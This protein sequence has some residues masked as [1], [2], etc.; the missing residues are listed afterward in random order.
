VGAIHPARPGAIPSARD[1]TAF[2]AISPAARRVRSLALCDD[3]GMRYASALIAGALVLAAACGEDQPSRDGSP[4]VLADPSRFPVVLEHDMRV[5]AR[6]DGS[7]YAEEPLDPW[8]VFPEAGA[9]PDG[10][11]RVLVRGGKV[12]IE[13]A[14]GG[15]AIAI[16]GIE[17]E[18]EFVNAAWSPDG[19]TLVFDASFTGASPAL[20]VVRADGSGLRDV[21]MGLDGDT[22]PLAWSPDA[23][24]FAFGVFG[25]AP[26][27]VSEL[28]TISADG[29]A[30]AA[31]GQFTI[32]Q[33][34]GGW[35]TAT[36][37]PDGSKIAAFGPPPKPGLRVF[38]IGGAPPLD[39]AGNVTRFSWSPDSRTI[40]YDQ[41]DAETQHIS[42]VI[43]DAST[44][45]VRELTEGFE[46]RWSPD[47]SRIAF[48][49]GAAS[50]GVSIEQAYTIR[51]DASGEAPVGPPGYYRFRDLV[52][53]ADSSELTFI[54]PAFG[55]A[56]LYRVDLSTA[57]AEP[58]GL[59]VGAVGDPPRVVEVSS[60][61]KH[62][63]LENYAS[64]A[65]AG[66]QVMDLATGETRPF[67]RGGA[68]VLDVYWG[69]EGPVIATGGSSLHVTDPVGSSARS[70]GIEGVYAGEFS[71]DG[72]RI[73]AITADGVWIVGSDGSDP[74]HIATTDAATEIAQQVDWSPDS[75]RL[76]YTISTFDQ[77]S[78]L[79]TTE[80]FVSDLGGTVT[81]VA[82][83]PRGVLLPYWSPDGA[84]LAQLRPGDNASAEIWLMDPEGGAVRLVASFE[85][86]CCG[87]LYWSP[88]STRIAVAAGFSSVSI[89]DVSSGDVLRAVTT[90][91][92]CNVNIAGW[93]ADSMTLYVY[94]AC[95]FGV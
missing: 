71:A 64:V 45:E 6:A 44:G 48:K 62:V 9:S 92:G 61:G 17:P 84:I 21:G 36:F 8:K 47:E 31:L 89:V 25:Q 88:D 94:P 24:I 59:P 79:S 7:G 20:Y 68:Q 2:V 75:T 12:V 85:G 63:L 10:A 60:D 38:D 81:E 22:T 93:S 23:R 16:A 82:S 72:S 83:D 50:L 43:G 91:G 39:F 29:A 27:Y 13:P 19:S 30:R 86:G 58:I 78:G 14:D 15:E 1:V 70:L 90:G 49:R 77:E 35:D 52:W 28:Y 76:S 87:D 67:E 18:E 5:T 95:Y 11:R 46:P 73:A 56:Q 80:A 74:R 65:D 51:P 42:V 53:S 69:P 57:A 3:A 33:G 4:S 55:Q 34:D 32:P 41:F 66:L 54:R 40:A 26:T 37:S